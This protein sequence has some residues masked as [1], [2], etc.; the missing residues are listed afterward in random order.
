MLC[1]PEEK[2]KLEIINNRG[3]KAGISEE[4]VSYE[5]LVA[6]SRRRHP[7][8]LPCVAE[9]EEMQEDGDDS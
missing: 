9:V 7:S 5:T 8:T 4:E 2:P 3:D 6:A 1:V